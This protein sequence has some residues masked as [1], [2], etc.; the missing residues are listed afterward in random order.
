MIAQ[1]EVLPDAVEDLASNFQGIDFDRLKNH[2]TKVL[3]IK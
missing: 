2:L 1:G 3:M